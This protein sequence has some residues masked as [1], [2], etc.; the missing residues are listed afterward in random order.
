MAVV[1]VYLIPGTMT[2]V[3]SGWC[4]RCQTPSVWTGPVWRLAPAGVDLHGQVTGCPDCASW[5]TE[6]AASAAA[7][8]PAEVEPRPTA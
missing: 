6:L 5:T 1:H 3:P 2:R 7:A 4:E 8:A